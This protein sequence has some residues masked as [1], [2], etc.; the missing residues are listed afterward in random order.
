[1]IPIMRKILLFRRE[2][3]IDKGIKKYQTN[4]VIMAYK[5]ITSD[6]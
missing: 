2:K 6:Q 1:M 5:E 3:N 4:I